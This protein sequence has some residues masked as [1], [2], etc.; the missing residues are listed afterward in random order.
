MLTAPQKTLA[1]ALGSIGS[2]AGTFVDM[3][4]RLGE[5]YSPTASL[6]AAW[7]IALV[8]TSIIYLLLGLLIKVR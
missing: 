3:H 6:I 4:G 2:G 8:V 7:A 5:R 1:Q